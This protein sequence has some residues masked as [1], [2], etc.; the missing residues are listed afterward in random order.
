MNETLQTIAKRY[1]CRAYTNQMPT[2]EQLDLIGK[3]ALAAPSGMNM[4]PWR[5]VIVKDRKLIDDLE[6]DAMNTLK[7]A[8]D[9]SAYNRIMSRG[10]KLFYNAP[11][12]VMVPIEPD[13]DHDCGILTEN[14]ALAAASM[15]LGNV[16][17]GM[18]GIPFAG[19]RSA[20]FKK[21][22]GFPEGFEFGMSIL[23][24]Y[25]AEDGKS[26]PLDMGKLSYIG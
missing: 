10:G 20:E 7:A 8:A 12:M 5:V 6:A 25:A 16:I 9:Q 18:A 19:P 4:Q 11:V 1:S 22:F 2:D 24:G 3:A 15:G 23:I 21:R 13:K 14:V 26:H 17:C